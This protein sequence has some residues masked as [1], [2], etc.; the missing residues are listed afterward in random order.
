MNS[1]G[2]KTKNTEKFAGAFNEFFT[3]M[4]P[5]LD[6]SIP[7]SQVDFH[8]YLKD[9]YLNSLYFY[10]TTEVEV[11]DI[12]SSSKPGA[13]IFLNESSPKVIQSVIVHI[14][15]PFCHIFNLWHYVIFSIYL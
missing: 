2:E 4:D 1:N 3:A 9:P 15:K 7:P 13:L 10:P 14:S 12:V 11:C 8:C 6:S 5:S